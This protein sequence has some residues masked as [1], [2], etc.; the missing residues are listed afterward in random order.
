MTITEVIANRLQLMGSSQSYIAE[1][2]G[3]NPTQLGVF[4]KGNGTLPNNV[5]NKILETVGIDLEIY[6]RR[7]QLANRVV[8]ILK[9]KNVTTIDNWSRQEIID[10]VKI[11]ELELF[12]DV[13]DLE[14]YIKILS[15]K[16]IDIESTFPY[17]KALVSYKLNLE[18]EKITSKTAYNA[19]LKTVNSNFLE[20]SPKYFSVVSLIAAKMGL[21][22]AATLTGATMLGLI[23]AG[24]AGLAGATYELPEAENKSKIQKGSFYLF[25][26]TQEE[27]LNKKAIEYIVKDMVD[28][29]DKKEKSTIIKP[30]ET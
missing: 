19:I 15:S 23:L 26:K 5:L 4:L 13:N 18:N 12:I 8:T 1:E 11:K 3:T 30:S 28:D 7:D 6:E 2:I 16:L 24:A 17:F 20:S 22:G 21:V 9:K 29:N 27:S 25:D 14:S 10:F